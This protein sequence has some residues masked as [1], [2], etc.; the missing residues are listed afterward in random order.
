[1]G[2]W[3]FYALGNDAGLDELKLLFDKSDLVRHVRSSLEQDLHEYPDEIRATVF[4]VYVL[5]KEEIWPRDTLREITSLALSR[6]T[7][8]LAEEVY[9]NANFVAELR[10]LIGQLREVEPA[11]L[12]RLREHEP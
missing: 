10:R 9:S 11:P 6:L 3:D 4:L 8:M 5:A 12:A 2:A 1:M 7:Q